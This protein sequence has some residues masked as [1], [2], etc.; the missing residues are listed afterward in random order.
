MSRKSIFILSSVA[1]LTATSATGAPRAANTKTMAATK[2]AT[3]AAAQKAFQ[4]VIQTKEFIALEQAGDVA[5]MQQSLVGTNV[6]VEPSPQL[7]PNC[8]P[9]YGVLAWGLQLHYG[10]HTYFNSS[11][12]TYVTHTANDAHWVEYC[13]RGGGGIGEVGLPPST[14]K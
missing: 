14:D 11:S 4:T 10:T 8:I 2:E 13:K 6:V 9:P 7:G 1:L 12:N 3:N 5:G